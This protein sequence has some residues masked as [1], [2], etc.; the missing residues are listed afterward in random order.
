[1][2]KNLPHVTSPQTCAVLLCAGA[3]FFD[4]DV[5]HF[6]SRITTSETLHFD[7]T[8]RFHLEFVT[9]TIS[10]F[11]RLEIA[12]ADIITKMLV[13]QVAQLKSLQELEISAE[14]VS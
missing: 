12:E 8:E 13:N 2:S 10:T 11:R 1:M 6:L 4:D 14:E 5:G 7:H 9:G 3:L